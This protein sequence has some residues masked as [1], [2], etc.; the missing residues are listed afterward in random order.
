MI[1]HDP[2]SLDAARKAAEGGDLGEWVTR[3]LASPGSDNEPLAAT[4]AE[5]NQSWTGPVRLPLSQLNR[6]AGPPED[7]VLCPVDDDEWHDRVDDMARRIEED[8]WEPTPL[9]VTYRNDQLVLE[10]GNHRAESLR[11]AGRED[12][13]AVVGF[14]NDADRA[15][16]DPPLA[17]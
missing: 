5:R 14:E 13:W 4:L 3:F 15:A 2:Y 8:G 1:D 9:I 6:L 7:P 11:R 17:S 12:V 10:D 16:F